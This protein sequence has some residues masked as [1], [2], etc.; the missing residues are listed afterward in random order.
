MEEGL[1]TLR[2]KYFFLRA[3]HVFCYD[4]LIILNPWALGFVIVLKKSYY[5]LMAYAE[6]PNALWMLMA[7]SFA[8]SSFFPLPPDPLLIAMVIAN[9]RNAWY[10]ST[11]CTLSSVI[12]GILGYY[13]GYAFYETLGLW[14]IHTYGL[15]ES[16]RNF[17][18]GFQ[19]WGFWII[20][21]KGLTPIPYKLVTIS[22][23]LA[24]F[25]LTQFLLASIIARGFRFFTL[26]GVLL[27]CGP[28]LRTYIERHFTWIATS[29][30]GALI[31]GFILFKYLYEIKTYLHGLF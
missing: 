1:R 25:D 8:E 26:T 9:R 20:A 16:F 31:L 4:N 27:L 5:R 13:I 2:C 28:Q 29:G 10:L 19:D 14:I 15:E 30:L 12:G 18:Q 24:R 22:S 23:G 6:R 11:L 3:L 17:Q 7:V 21:L